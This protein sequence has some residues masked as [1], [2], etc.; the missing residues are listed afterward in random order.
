MAD[1]FSS[2]DPVGATVKPAPAR[3]VALRIVAIMANGAASYAAHANCMLE[4]VVRLDIAI[5]GHRPA[6]LVKDG[7]PIDLPATTIEF[8]KRAAARARS[9]GA[10]QVRV[11]TGGALGV[12]QEVAAAVAAHP[13]VS[14]IAF[15]YTVI[16]PFPIEIMG[17][18]WSAS[19]RQRLADLVATA[20]ESPPPI[21]SSFASWAYHARNA[22]MVDASDLVMAFWSGKKN[23]GTYQ[24]L[25]YA[26]MNAKPPRL[27]YNALNG[28]LP[29]RRDAV[30]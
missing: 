21:T 12:D 6:D 25:R 18:Y 7:Q 24:C 19:D 11:I 4:S 16:L 20:A 22:A 23:G 13:E 5:T 10:S 15:E 8:L 2:A 1:K 9:L 28:F 17:K 29:I 3:D 27:C 30:A 14:G 26:L